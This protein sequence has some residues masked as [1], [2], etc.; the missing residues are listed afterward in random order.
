MCF[1]P[2]GLPPPIFDT[3]RTSV[4][5]TLA[6]VGEACHTTWSGATAA[7]AILSSSTFELFKNSGGTLTAV[8]AAVSNNATS[9]EAVLNPNA[10]LA[11]GT[12]YTAKVTTG[13]KDLSGNALAETKPFSFTTK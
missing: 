13:V 3:P 1:A 5:R 8:S 6:A 4:S 9:K 11:S 2:R 12:R 7:K 10:I